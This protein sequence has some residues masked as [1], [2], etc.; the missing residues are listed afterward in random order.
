MYTH[1]HTHQV[2]FHIGELCR[3]LLA[4]PSR[5]TDAQ[6]CVR[7]AIGNGLRLQ[8]W[9]Q[10]QKRFSIKRIVEFYGSTEGNVN[11]IN[12]KG[13]PGACGAISVILPFLNP[14]QLIKVDETGKHVRNANG[15][16]VRAGVDEPGEAVGSIDIR[17]STKHFDGYEDKNA[18]SK[19]ILKN[20]FKA[21]DQ[22][23]L[24]GDILRMDEEGYVY[25]CDRTGDTFRWK[26]EN[27]STM[28]IEGVIQSILEHRDAAVYGV[29]VPGMEGRAGMAAIVGTARTVPLTTLYQQLSLSLPAYAVPL[30]V[31][32][33]TVADTTGTHKLKK[34]GL[35]NEGCNP[36]NISDPVFFLHPQQ[37][38]Y[39]P[40]T[41]QI[42]EDIVNGT[43]RL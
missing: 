24:S 40:F 1:T 21:G 7:M 8:I 43:I 12:V 20:V 37:K 30:F 10:F 32:F 42:Y 41:R 6:H 13:K 14:L 35:R 22:Y 39:V 38:A 29:E 26:G 11:V 5:P 17:I 3:Y 2:V 34:V 19:K 28:E 18:T 33:I 36:D 27:V 4:Q 9:K 16:C 31:R 15:Y 25:F 23:F